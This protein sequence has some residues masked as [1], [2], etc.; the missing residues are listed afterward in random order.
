[1]AMSADGVRVAVAS[2]AHPENGL[3]IGRVWIVNCSNGTAAVEAVLTPPVLHNYMVFGSALSFDESGSVLIVGARGM[4]G[5]MGRVFGYRRI[6]GQWVQEWHQPSGMPDNFGASTAM[7][8]AGDLLAVGAPNRPNPN[9]GF[10][11]RGVIEVYR[12]EHDAWVQ[13]SVIS[14]GH[15]PLARYIGNAL[16]MSRDGKTLVTNSGGWTN[17]PVPNG[18]VYVLERTATGWVQIARLQEPVAY[19]WG[20]WGT[21]FAMDARAEWLAVGNFQDSRVSYGQGAVSIFHKLSSGWQ[22]QTALLPSQPHQSWAFGRSLSMNT[23][24]D[25]MR[26]GAPGAPFGSLSSAGAVEE[27]EVLGGAWVR[28]AVHFAPAPE[29]AANFG[30]FVTN[31]GSA[32]GV[33]W[34]ASEVQSDAFHPDAGQIHFF[35]AACLTPTVYCTAQSNSLGCVPRVAF[36]GSPSLSGSASFTISAVDVRNQQNGMLIYGFNGRSAL[37]WLGGTLCVQPPLRRT[38]LL[39]SGGAAPPTNDCSGVLARDFNAWARTAGDPVLFPGQH[40]RTQFYSRDPGAPSNLN[41]TDALEFY[42]EL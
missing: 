17:H 38:P 34:I 24:G 2:G 10:A 26:V 21:A 15:L 14:A 23:A 31:D 36:Q 3:I 19:S 12:R 4:N 18:A 35:E 37:P 40:V 41:L 39:Q 32:S 42:L 28:T 11:E 33:R 13:D 8:A 29:Q 1:M 25:R 16:A 27:F 7:S 6:N 5:H 9:M 20:G 22:Y 30:S